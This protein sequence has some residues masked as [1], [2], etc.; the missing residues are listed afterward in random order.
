MVSSGVFWWSQTFILDPS[1]SY[2]NLIQFIIV[3]HSIFVIRVPLSLWTSSYFCICFLEVIGTFSQGCL[4]LRCGVLVPGWLSGTDSSVPAGDCWTFSDSDHWPPLWL[5]LMCFL[6]LLPFTPVHYAEFDTNGMMREGWKDWNEMIKAVQRQK[7]SI[8]LYIW[9]QKEYSVR[10]RCAGVTAAAGTSLLIQPA[11]CSSS[12]VHLDNE[13]CYKPTEPTGYK[14]TIWA[15]QVSCSW[16]P[17][18]T[19]RVLP[20]M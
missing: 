9:L 16:I 7:F 19:I 3:L 4:C 14:V 12:P 11:T 15:S 8:T 10:S 5:G 20:S 1:V 6:S 2:N 13:C 17:I 18:S